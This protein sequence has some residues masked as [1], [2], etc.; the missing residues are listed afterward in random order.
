MAATDVTNQGATFSITN[1]K[2]Y[3]PI[4]TLSTQNNAKLLKQ[5]KSAF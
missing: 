2:I 5:S 1:A 3:A 4:L